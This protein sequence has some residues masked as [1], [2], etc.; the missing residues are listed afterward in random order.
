MPFRAPTTCLPS[1]LGIRAVAA[2]GGLRTV[3]V[4]AP[5]Q[6]TSHPLECISD[7]VS[8][9]RQFHGSASHLVCATAALFEQR[10]SWASVQASL[11]RRPDSAGRPAE[12]EPT[13][14]A[15]ASRSA[16][17]NVG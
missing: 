9:V 17:A 15:G 6:S 4:L 2:A 10:F 11:R 5:R 3:G 13:I 14:R 1:L 8:H 12:W 7:T 16:P